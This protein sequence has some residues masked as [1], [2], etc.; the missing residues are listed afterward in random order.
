MS[1][2]DRPL[3]PHLQVY[4]IQ[5][6]STLSILHRMTGAGLA[7]GAVLLAWW[8]FAALCGDEAFALTQ[9][10]RDHIIGKV[11]LFG[12]L[13]AF[14][15]HFLN[16]LRHLVWDSGHGLDL[17]SAYRSGWAVVVCSVFLTLA[18]WCTAGGMHVYE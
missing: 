17:K 15:Y 1:N 9:Q 5:L 16:G 11:M 13:F 18:V 6:T 3:S 8:L 10:F 12:W 14:I 4:K 2:N 7:V